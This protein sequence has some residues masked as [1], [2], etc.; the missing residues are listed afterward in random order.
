MNKK[1]ISLK[2]ALVFQSNMVLQAQKKI[3]IWGEDEPSKLVTVEIFDSKKELSEKATGLA[4]EL[5]HWMVELGPHEVGRDY[6]I[7]ISSESGEVVLDNVAMGEVWLAGGQSN[8]EFPLDFDANC[9][10]TIAELLEKK[11]DIRF[12]DYPEV[13]YEGQIDEFEYVNTGIWRVPSQEDLPN[14][15]AVGL[16][17]AKKL[18]E[19]VDAPIGII[20]CNWGGTTACSWLD[21]KLLENSADDIWILDY[22]KATKNLDIDTYIRDFKSNPMNHRDGLLNDPISLDIEKASRSR[23]EQLEMMKTFDPTGI[24]PV[25]GPYYERRPGGL[26]ETMLKK[27]APYGLRGFIWYQGESDDAHPNNYES[28]LTKLI[29]NW[30]SLWADESLPFLFVQL[31]PFR[32]WLATNGFAYPILRE[33]QDRVSKTLKNTYMASIGDVGMEWDI[34][35]KN[36]KPVGERLGLLALKNIYGVSVECDAPEICKATYNNS[37]LTLDIKNGKGL[38][39]KGDKMNSLVLY[40]EKNEIIHFDDFM[41]T[42]ENIVIHH[43]K[44]PAKVCFAWEAYYEVNVFNAAG[45]PMK[46]YMSKEGEIEC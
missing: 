39:L 2:P 34:H 4:N 16:Y 31:A 20:G 1:D 19:Y 32:E 45:I 35:P 10:Q 6:S 28:V 13:S 43:V 14:Y 30:R 12:F 33:A 44:Q 3:K 7:R 37:E 17:F 38:H 46:P 22:E 42:D 5:G 8:M 24:V 23:E 18:S 9:D 15:S 29:G 27:L 41:I 26:Y 25:I 36:K 11:T 40:D 21:P